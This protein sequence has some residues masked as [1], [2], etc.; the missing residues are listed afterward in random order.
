VSTIK[1]KDFHPRD[2]DVSDG[3]CST[4]GCTEFE[5]A[6]VCILAYLND[7]SRTVNDLGWSHGEAKCAWRK[8]FGVDTFE[9]KIGATMFAMLA[10]GGWFTH[11]WFPKGLFVV[12]ETFIERLL[13]RQNAGGVYLER[14]KHGSGHAPQPP[15]QVS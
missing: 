5:Q 9:P 14:I 8:R 3:L 1:L 13:W 11:V 7:D 15:Y 12:S 2:V 4:F 10:C 6:A